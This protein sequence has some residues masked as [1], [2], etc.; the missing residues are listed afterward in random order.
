MYQALELRTCVNGRKVRGARRRD[1]RVQIGHIREFVRH[2]M[3]KPGLYRRPKGT[4]GLQLWERLPATD[5]ELL[6]IGEARRGT[7]RAENTSTR[8][9]WCFSA[10]PDAAAWEAVEL[11]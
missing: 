2:D 6:R 5:L 8:P 7:R 3:D 10:L 9:T 4:T 11:H 1:N